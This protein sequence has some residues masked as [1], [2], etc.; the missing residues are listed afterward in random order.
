MSTPRIFGNDIEVNGTVA[1]SETSTVPTTNSSHGILYID[2][3]SKD[4]Y[5]KDTAG[6]VFNISQPNNSV[7]GGVF[8]TSITPNESGKN[9]NATTTD[10][11]G[12][13]VDSIITN[14]QL[15]RVNVLAIT[16]NSHYMPGVT[17]NGIAIT[18]M[19]LTTDKTNWAGYAD[20]TLGSATSILVVHED[21]AKS[22]VAVTMD[23]GPAVTAL[24][25]TG[26]Y[27]GTQ[28]E[29]KP[30]DIYSVFVQTNTPMDQI[31]VYDEGASVAN[32]YAVSPAAT[33]YTI[34]ITV[35][36]RGGVTTNQ[37]V[38]LKCRNSNGSFGSD[39]RTDAGGSV[40]GVNLVKLNNTFPN[41]V[42]GIPVYPSG[43]SALKGTETAT[44]T[45]TV[46][47]ANTILFTSP[48]SEI[49]ISNPTIIEASKNATRI[50]GTYNISTN[51]VT[52]TMTRTANN[53]VTVTNAIV[54]VANVAPTITIATPAARLMSGGTHGT[55]A[56]NYVITVTANQYLLNA[57]V[58]NLVQGSGAG[59]WQGAGFAGSNATW[60][61]SL[62]VSDA[63]DSKGTF[64]F[65]I[66]SVINLAGI[67]GTVI[68]SG[69]N[70][71][72]GGFVLRTL[73]IAAWGNRMTD[74]GTNVSD[75]SKLRCTNFSKGSL[76]GAFDCIYQATTAEGTFKFTITNGAGTPMPTGNFWYN[77]DTPNAVSNTTG[78]AQ[79]EIEE[80]P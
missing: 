77:V 7:N 56:Q 39:A 10:S 71:V 2:Q 34:S 35:A 60:T 50:G 55:A 78:T 17:V 21:G 24:Y 38:R 3:T 11:G 73:T 16:G 5:F 37:W 76:P 69:T 63:L 6:N 23:T 65:A 57:P 80:L 27:P 20:I 31:S 66:G 25:F 1:L 49:G 33:T 14:T 4:L 61:R 68:T 29:L 28:T 12:L 45:T 62:Q 43:Q 30:G 26:G 19:T 48:G 15:L 72:L 52:A 40:D 67:A 47:N 18:N 70:Y 44:I 75:T 41:I 8:V 58:I 9:V 32:V 64:S 42:F 51:N 79:I 59:T 36:N 53:A 54:N 13:V 74:I 22:T 46:S